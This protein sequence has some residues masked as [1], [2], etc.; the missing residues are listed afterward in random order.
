MVKINW[1]RSFYNLGLMAN[2]LAFASLWIPDYIAQYPN[3]TATVNFWGSDNNS[4]LEINASNYF[5]VILIIAS[6]VALLTAIFYRKR[7]MVIVNLVV[8]LLSSLG[9]LYWSLAQFSSINF[10]TEVSSPSSVTYAPGIFI[11]FFTGIILLM[12][13]AGIFIQERK[14]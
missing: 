10:L 12:C 11:R 1:L 4:I 6:F 5:I 8:S 9:L 2:L 14:S 7:P 13:V 3:G